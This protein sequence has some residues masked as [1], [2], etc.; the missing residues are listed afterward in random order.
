MSA[1][2]D[3]ELSLRPVAEW[4][5]PTEPD[6]FIRWMRDS[7]GSE[8]APG[9]SRGAADAERWRQFKTFPAFAF[10]P[11]ALV[12]A[13]DERFPPEELPGSHAVSL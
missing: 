9:E 7:V 1:L 11:K 2:E 4:N 5:L 12:K 13:L 3:D 8:P 10:A 6:A